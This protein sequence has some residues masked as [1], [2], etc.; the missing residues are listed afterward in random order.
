M[1][2]RIES[3]RKPTPLHPASLFYHE[4]ERVTAAWD[5]AR[6]LA[7]YP[8]ADTLLMRRNALIAQISRCDEQ[9]VAR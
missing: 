9:T 3:H 8:L 2:A 7:H 6:A 1:I 5:Q 4:L